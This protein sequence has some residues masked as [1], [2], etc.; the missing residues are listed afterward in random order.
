MKRRTFLQ[1]LGAT[2]LV[3][4]LP[5]ASVTPSVS[6]SAVA[7][8]PVVPAS[9]YKW[10]EVIVRAHNSCNLAMLQRHLQ[11]D[12]SVASV[13]KSQLLQKGVISAEVNAYG[14]H[15]AVN[16][17]LQGSFPKPANLPQSVSSTVKEVTER[18]N[19]VEYAEEATKDLPADAQ[20]DSDEITCEP[21][22]ID[23]TT[24][25]TNEHPVSHA[26]SED[27]LHDRPAADDRLTQ[28]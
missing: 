3:P 19:S 21:S 9:V 25:I 18:L 26:P 16:P 6:G 1:S 22:P 23:E 7:A 12:A 13:L 14:I 28:P 15:R 4:A 11:I 5:F 20:P 24:K 27:Q 10:A 17:I 2:A 8:A